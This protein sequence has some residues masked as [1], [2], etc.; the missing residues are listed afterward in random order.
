MSTTDSRDH[1]TNGSDART[2][3]NAGAGAGVPSAAGTDAPLAWGTGT[4]MKSL[5]AVMWR[6][7]HDPRMRST[8]V[9]VELL[10]STPDWD[11]FVS[12][13]E[14]ASR[15]V[16]RFRQ[17][18]LEPAMGL[19]R[20]VWSND[21][22]FDLHYH[23]RRIGLP[24]PGT[25]SEILATAQQMA[26]TPFDRH[27]APWEAA[28]VE[29]LPDGKAAYLL[30]LHHS[31]TDGI[32]AT[33]L[34]SQMHS[35]QREPNPDKPQPPNPDAR[36]QTSLE[37]IGRQL[38]DDAK[39]LT[40]LLGITGRGLRALTKPDRAVA[41]T[42]RYAA[43][44]R[45]V[46]ADPDAEPSPLLRGR[47]MSWRFLA[48]DLAFADL[49]GASKPHGASLNDAYIAG[50][51]GA[52]RIYH[53]EMGMPIDKMP[54]ALPISI[55][56]A[57]DE[58]G[59][60]AFAGARLAGPVGI[61]NPLHRMQIIGALVGKARH[62]PAVNG[63]GFLAPA[64]ARLPG[65]AITLLAGGITKGNDLQASNVPG[66]RE[67]VFLA[68]AKIERAYPFAPLPGCAAMITMLSHGDTCCIGANLDP[69]A[70]TDVERFARCMVAGFEEVLSLKSGAGPV[71]RKA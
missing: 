49:R 59:G 57:G 43:S 68:G 55:R 67:D 5:E 60:N 7:E 70:I 17:K 65:P 58:D 25:F 44:L 32:G 29:G 8:M 40:G 50:L 1:S 21:P 6:A 12:A 10:D 36:P 71:L 47:S 23:V 15:M 61:T 42:V 45:R 62:E 13:H 63:L 33:Q 48:F 19:G 2:S 35:R 20:P 38:A 27:R 66:I 39:G 3:A 69:A 11:R 4:E 31:A 51:L 41:D 54:M 14:W 53:D 46:L 34:L 9:A 26:M 22:D 24:V 18:V 64:L 52:F 56:K 16:P 28:L 30:K 37:A